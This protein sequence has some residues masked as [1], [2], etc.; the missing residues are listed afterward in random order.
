MA[1]HYFTVKN[2]QKVIKEHIS[3]RKTVTLTQKKYLTIVG[4]VI[5]SCC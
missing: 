4:K 3:R 1:S 2:K 5:H